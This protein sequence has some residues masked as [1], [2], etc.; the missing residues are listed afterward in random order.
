MRTY[1]GTR[2]A[3]EGVQRREVL[4]AAAEF[5]GLFLIFIVAFTGREH[6]G[7]TIRQLLIAL[8]FIVSGLGVGAGL[9]ILR[10]GFLFHNGRVTRLALGA[11]M[12]FMGAY[13]I[14]HVAS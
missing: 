10:R 8:T 4:A 5:V 14:V 9:A 6:F 7:D 13:S 11:V 2:P 1:A 3:G 12:I